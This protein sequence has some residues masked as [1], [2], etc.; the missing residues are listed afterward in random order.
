MA[1][2]M[3]G[4]LTSRDC[5]RHRSLRRLTLQCIVFHNEWEEVKLLRNI[6]LFVRVLRNM[7][8]Y[9]LHVPIKAHREQRERERKK[10]RERERERDSRCTETVFVSATVDRVNWPFKVTFAAR[11]P[12]GTHASARRGERWLR[13]TVADINRCGLLPKNRTRVGF[14]WARCFQPDEIPNAMRLTR[15]RA[16]VFVSD[17]RVASAM[18][19]AMTNNYER[20]REESGA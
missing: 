9:R 16:R 14:N 18:T 3:N 11:S 15:D 4:A 12:Q 20:Q 1:E 8:S 7:Q 19:S 5:A 10:E 2:L 13:W 17:I 6:L